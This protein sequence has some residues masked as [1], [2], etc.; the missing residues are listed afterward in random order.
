MNADQVHQVQT[1]LVSKNKLFVI[2]SINFSTIALEICVCTG[3]FVS[4]VCPFGLFHW[5][6][7][8]ISLKLQENWMNIVRILSLSSIS[9]LI[10]KNNF[11]N[12]VE[13]CQWNILYGQTEK[14]KW[15]AFF[16]I[17]KAIAKELTK[18]IYFLSKN[19]VNQSPFSHAWN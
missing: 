18:K 16:D 4:S 12:V 13:K 15:S 10:N 9:K 11:Q 3:H 14:N 6:K 19:Y 17:F 8:I 5:N 1:S 2:F 7:F